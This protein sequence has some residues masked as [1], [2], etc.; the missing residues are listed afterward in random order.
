MKLEFDRPDYC[1]GCTHEDLYLK[2]FEL[3]YGD[4]VLTTHTMHCQHEKVCDMWTTRM[5]QKLKNRSEP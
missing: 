4:D 3:H 5:V 2:K 1:E